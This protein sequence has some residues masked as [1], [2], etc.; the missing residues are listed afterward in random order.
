MVKFEEKFTWKDIYNFLCK[1]KYKCKYKCKYLNQRV[2]RTQEKNGKLSRVFPKQKRKKR[3]SFI[4][5]CISETY[6][7]VVGKTLEIWKH[8]NYT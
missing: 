8:L 6:S 2:R 1:Y 4:T 5:Q 7:S 3:L